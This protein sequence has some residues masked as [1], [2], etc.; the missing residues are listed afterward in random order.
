M[1]LI[2]TL[3]SENLWR[4]IHIKDGRL[5]FVEKQNIIDLFENSKDKEKLG[6]ASDTPKKI[7]EFV[8]KQLIEFQGKKITEL[9][10]KDLQIQPTKCVASFLKEKGFLKIDIFYFQDERNIDKNILEFYKSD[11]SNQQL[12]DINSFT[13]IWS[14][15]SLEGKEVKIDEI[16]EIL[17]SYSK[18]L[19]YENLSSKLNVLSSEKNILKENIVQELGLSQDLFKTREYETNK[20]GEQTS[21]PLYIKILDQK[22]N[23]IIKT[24]TEEKYFY[25]ILGEFEKLAF[26]IL[27]DN[28]TFLSLKRRDYSDYFISIIEKNLDKGLVL[29]KTT[30]KSYICLDLQE[31]FKTVLAFN[32]IIKSKEDLSL[33]NIKFKELYYTWDSYITEDDIKKEQRNYDKKEKELKKFFFEYLQNYIIESNDKDFIDNRPK[34]FKSIISYYR[35]EK[36]VVKSFFDIYYIEKKISS[37]KNIAPEI[38]IEYSKYFYNQVDYISSLKIANLAINHKELSNDLKAE[39]FNQIASCFID[40]NLPNFAEKACQIGLTFKSEIHTTRIYGNQAR[41]LIK[42]SSF[43]NQDKKILFHKAVEL[44]KNK[45]DKMIEQNDIEKASYLSYLFN[46]TKLEERLKNKSIEIMNLYLS[47]KSNNDRIRN[48]TDLILGNSFVYRIKNSEEL[49]NKAIENFNS[50]RDDIYSLRNLT[51][52][53]PYLR[54]KDEKNISLIE[55]IQKDLLEKENKHLAGALGTIYL[56]IGRY[57]HNNNDVE[58]AKE[59][60]QKAID[61]FKTINYYTESYITNSYLYLLDNNNDIKNLAIE[62]YKNIYEQMLKAFKEVSEL[63]NYLDDSLEE[64]FSIPDVF[65]VDKSKEEIKKILDNII[66][67]N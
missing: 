13:E 27:T 22:L 53:F 18:F 63:I 49:F 17:S 51:Y 1:F 40:I 19:G 61:I 3:G 7:K 8:L 64:Q 62:N 45:L 47:E 29:S 2:K 28:I 9:I 4:I 5:S 32:H 25:Q 38:L 21:K 43:D 34:L 41:V 11:F 57:Y 50:Q 12:L 65:A 10:E 54:G 23:Q 52:Y 14:K 16:D 26:D 46:Q 67:L 42:K 59:Y 24:Y 58:K 35:L 36:K 44:Y 30:D 20:N 39:I 48:N 6:K 15:K 31:D 56:N 37:G 33:D 60:Y 55:N 66:Y